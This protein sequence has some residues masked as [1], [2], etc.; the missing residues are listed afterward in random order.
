MCNKFT[1]KMRSF[2]WSGKLRHWCNE[3]E[4]GGAHFVLIFRTEARRWFDRNWEVLFDY[5]FKT[6]RIQIKCEGV[7][8]NLRG[9]CRGTL[10]IVMLS[11]ICAR[12]YT[13]NFVWKK[14]ILSSSSIFYVIFHNKRSTKRRMNYLWFLC[15]VRYSDDDAKVEMF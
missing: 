11:D 7:Q 8:S 2:L 10:S 14:L 9:G 1:W 13:K 12:D 6:I 4:K 15:F 3:T 5:D